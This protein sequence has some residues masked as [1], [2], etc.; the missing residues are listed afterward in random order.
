MLTLS[1]QITSFAQVAIEGIQKLIG[2]DHSVVQLSTSAIVIMATTVLVKGVVW[3]WC[4]FIKNSSVQALAQDAVTDVVFNTFSIIFPLI[5]FYAKIWWLDPLGGILL[6]FWV[7]RDW[8]GR[9]QGDTT[10]SAARHSRKC[11]C[12]TFRASGTWFLFHGIV[13]YSC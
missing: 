11:S 9:R 4:R 10:L 7:R 12:R 8:Q 1:V 3:L 13:C 2:P 6:S 5:G